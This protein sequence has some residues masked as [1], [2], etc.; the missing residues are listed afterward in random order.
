MPGRIT[1]DVVVMDYSHYNPS[2]EEGVATN[3]SEIVDLENVTGEF[4][5]IN[6][7]F[8]F[9]FGTATG[10]QGNRGDVI[11]LNTLLNVLELIATELGFEDADILGKFL[12]VKGLQ[13]VVGTPVQDT[14]RGSQGE[15]FFYG[16]GGPDIIDAQGG[17]DTFGFAPLDVGGVRSFDGPV[18]INLADG[19]AWSGTGGD[20]TPTKAVGITNQGVSDT[21]E[22]QT[23]SHDAVS[24]DLV[25][26]FDGASFTL[27]HDADAA[28]LKGALEGLTGLPS[29]S[30]GSVTVGVTGDGSSGTPFEITFTTP[31]ATDVPELVFDGVAAT[32]TILTDT[33][34]QAAVNEVQTLSN[35]GV[36][37]TFKLSFNDGT[38]T[39]TTG[40]IAFNA[41]DSA[42]E[43]AL[44]TLSNI[45]D[46]TVTGTGQAVVNEVQ[47][48]SHDGTAGTFTLFF[49]DGT[50]T[51]TTAAIAF[52]AGDSAVETAL[53]ALSNITD[54]SVTGTGT[55][56]DPWVVEFVDPG[57]QN[58]SQITLDTNN[59]LQTNGTAGNV[60]IATDLEGRAAVNEV[61]T[62]SHDAGS[63]D[64]AFT[65]D[66]ASFTLAHDAVAA[67]LK[68]A[69]EG[70]ASA[71][72]STLASVVVD[73]TGDGSSGTP[74]EITFSAPAG[75]DVPELVFDLVNTTAV[76]S[77]GLTTASIA[78]STPGAAAENEIQTLSVN[79]AAGAFKLSFNGQTTGSIDHEAGASDV[80][81][82]LEDLSNIGTRNVQ[83]TR[84]QSGP[85][86]VWEV[87]FQGSLAGTNVSKIQ[88]D[89][90]EFDL[91]GRRVDDA[92]LTTLI[93]VE[94]AVSGPGDDLLIGDFGGSEGLEKDGN[95][96]TPVRFASETTTQGDSGASEVQEVS[97][98][99]EKGNFTLSFGDQI[100]APIAYDA[101]GSDVEDALEAL[102]DIGSGNVVVSRD[103]ST[104][105]D[106]TTFT[107]EITFQD[108]LANQNIGD[109]IRLHPGNEESN[110]NDDK[111]I[112][113]SY[114]FGEDWGK[115]LVIDL[116]GDNVLDFT[117]LESDLKKFTLTRLLTSNGDAA[118]VTVASTP[119]LEVHGLS[120]DAVA[121]DLAF[122]F[123][124]VSFTLAHDADA[125][126]LEDALNGLTGLSTLSSVVVAV[127][128]D[129]S[130]GTPFEITFTTPGGDDT[131]VPELV[132]DSASTT[133]V[134]SGGSTAAATISTDSETAATQ[135][136]STDADE[137]HFV[138][139][140]GNGLTTPIAHNASASDVEDALEGLSG[141][142]EGNVVVTGSGTSVDPWTVTF[143]GSLANQSIAEFGAVFTE[144]G[145]TIVE[146]GDDRV[147]A[148]GVF[149][150]EPASKSF[151]TDTFKVI[152]FSPDV[153]LT[154][155]L[156]LVAQAAA[157]AAGEAPAILTGAQLTTL[158]DEALARWSA[159][160]LAAA[161]PIDLAGVTFEIADLNGL[162]LAETSGSLIR[163]DPTAAGLGW[164]VD[165]TPA[166][167]LEFGQ[168]LTEGALLAVGDSPAVG[169][170]DL[171]TVALHELGHILGLTDQISQGSSN[172]LMGGDLAEGVRKAI[173]DFDPATGA[174]TAS[175]SG[176]MEA[177]PSDEEKLSLGLGVFADWTRNFGED[178]KSVFD[179]LPEVPFTGQSLSDL[180][181]LGDIGQLANE[182]ADKI[183]LKVD[184]L[185]TNLQ[186]VF[187]DD[188]FPEVTVQT[189]LDNVDGLRADPTSTTL[190]E[191]GTTLEVARFQ[192]DITLDFAF[193]TDLGLTINQSTPIVMTITL[194]V[195]FNFGIDDEGRFFV[196]DPTLIGHFTLDHEEPLDISL[197]FGP[198][199]VGVEDG[200]LNFDVTLSFG[201]DGRLTFDELDADKATGG[202][203]GTPKM[204]G[205]A[206]YEI[207]LPVALQGALAG[208]QDEPG[209]IQASFGNGD[210]SEDTSLSAFFTSLG[211]SL[212]TLDLDDLIQF[213]DLSIEFLLDG[214][215]LGLDTLVGDAD[216]DG[217]S[218]GL[219]FQ[220][221]PLIDKSLV[222]LL[223]S[224]S[225]NVITDIKDALIS[226][227]AALDNMQNF[228]IDLNFAIDSAL[229]L[230][231]SLGDETALKE[232]LGRL[233]A[234]SFRLDGDS[235]DA[236]ISTALAD[237]QLVADLIAD[238][239]VV[240]A[241]DRLSAIDSDLDAD[242]DNQT[243]AEVL[244]R[245]VDSA[246]FDALIA[247][248]DLVAAN[249][250]FLDAK[251][252]LDAPWAHRRG[253]GRRN[254]RPPAGRDHRA[255]PGSQGNCRSR[256]GRERRAPGGPRPPGRLRPH[257][258]DPHG[259][260]DRGR[261]HRFQRDPVRQ[262]RPGSFGGEG[263][264]G[265]FRPGRRFHRQRH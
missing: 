61:Q 49:D 106:E 29:V 207:F 9:S 118:T 41:I 27:A 233:Q 85:T 35:D 88:I 140:F 162:M 63:G 183:A 142:G 176:T 202:L 34:S 22:V 86:Y 70:L 93:G 95:D 7:E 48:I 12:G 137:G 110:D 243:I 59:L 13:T 120:H 115:D 231:L 136:I 178:L 105:G 149:E 173:P 184:G 121:G 244:A 220:D 32:T 139:K 245:A 76:Q 73:V 87:E 251:A 174:P 250:E 83:V 203:I 175:V 127:T 223:G 43:T 3:V 236:E 152:D 66:G 90:G 240:A 169:G 102:S 218:D 259:F 224:G 4:N 6:T 264:P 39:E 193:L 241:Q 55:T 225:V 45:T 125:Q 25:F 57:D 132:L 195:D 145:M 77:G 99:G 65:F 79:A 144:V 30:G 100:T 84:T 256:N 46:V 113:H 254:Q 208:L 78:E 135:E 107:W 134:N 114:V 123:D 16:F 26:T 164:F 148:I 230:G 242:S 69:L 167:D 238:R 131:D 104:S 92:D 214:I 177:D 181:G 126:A 222:D 252:L 146:N 72:L 159:S 119:R 226:V 234:V 111:P 263:S 117:N 179:G 155:N 255:G 150:I 71:D 205:D 122:T 91:V 258:T 153:A 192:S 194:D 37:G 198:L 20:D 219:A 200:T 196:K 130:S 74:F 235:T 141:I 133:A 166:D 14:L 239:E 182:F 28:A 147:T 188:T 229:D 157:Q 23:L 128:G 248:R 103:K 210:T 189:L 191:F 97:H 212:L 160:D 265:R 228:E 170:V 161:S 62:L 215:I 201:T 221:L 124:G 109:Q 227:K 253:D 42:V 237:A 171:L 10:I 151:G 197:A 260:G 18:T 31:A 154:R 33:S 52:D 163:I 19:L 1:G 54:V 165:S 116:D 180:L 15:D 138:L 60:S 51:E 50:T 8:G 17:A 2:G 247:D 211:T 68:G 199:G 58:V 24:G 262:R 36:S 11:G 186:A 261:P 216:G 5:I 101:T 40:D 75:T 204:G 156:P 21:N 185:A 96:S 249:A 56:A 47:K 112:A 232:A 98:T 172:I 168:T 80:E 53:E 89:A 158:V 44:E 64:L 213:K 206:S 94:K 257:P 217:M 209:V 187:D 38:T 246:G 129:G 108:A 67:D 82:E 81:T 190:R 143:Q